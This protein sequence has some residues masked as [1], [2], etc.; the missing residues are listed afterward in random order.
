MA[1]DFKNSSN[2]TK[3]YKDPLSGS[4][5]SD[6]GNST[7]IGFKNIPTVKSSDSY[8]TSSPSTN[9]RR[10]NSRRTSSPYT[11]YRRSSIEIP[12][13][14]VIIVLTI[15]III[16]CLWVYRDVIT[17]FLMRLLSWVITLLIIV[18]LIKWFIFPRRK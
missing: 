7:N 18:F 6:S 11:S 17:A 13:R 10:T 12:W 9:T 2:S 3:K 15:V 5:Y 8:L 4:E 1:F 16:S 14:L